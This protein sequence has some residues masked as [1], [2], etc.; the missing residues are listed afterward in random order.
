MLCYGTSINWQC[1]ILP[2]TVYH[3]LLW[4]LERSKAEIKLLVLGG[5]QDIVK[6]NEDEE[7]EDVRNYISVRLTL[8]IDL[9]PMWPMCHPFLTRMDCHCSNHTAAGEVLQHLPRELSRYCHF[10]ET[11][12]TLSWVVDTFTIYLRRYAVGAFVAIYHVYKQVWSV[13]VGDIL[14]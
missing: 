9:S 2:V 14:Y 6:M 12:L 7:S 11:L 10:W 5:N 3:L 4:F 13:S 1:Y 8:S